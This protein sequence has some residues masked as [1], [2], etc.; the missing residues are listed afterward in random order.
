MV[1]GSL[2]TLLFMFELLRRRRLR[3]KYAALWIGVAPERFLRPSR[4]ALA[5]T[6]AEY[7]AGVARAAVTTPTL[8]PPNPGPANRISQQSSEGGR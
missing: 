7:Q 4:P 5:A 3:E 1:V 2:L 6:L 8:R